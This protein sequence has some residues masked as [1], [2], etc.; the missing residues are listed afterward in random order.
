M[1]KRNSLTGVVALGALAY[2]FRN[3]ESRD[4]VINKVKSTFGEDNISKVKSKLPFL[5]SDQGNTRQDH[6]GPAYVD[7]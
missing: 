2:M 3:K 5:N 6:S 7:R 1:S 4:K